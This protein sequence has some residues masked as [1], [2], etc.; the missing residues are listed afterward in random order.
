MQRVL[1]DIECR[2]EGATKELHE[3]QALL[4]EIDCERTDH[5]PLLSLLSNVLVQF[6]RLQSHRKIVLRS[7]SK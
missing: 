1:A 7:M 4:A 3:Q 2:L 6:Q 5:L